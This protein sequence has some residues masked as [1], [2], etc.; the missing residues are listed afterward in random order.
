[1]GTGCPEKPQGY[2]CHSL[3]WREWQTNIEVLRG[4]VDVADEGDGGGVVEAEVG[5]GR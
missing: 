3:V 4:E 1:M 2:P 5:T